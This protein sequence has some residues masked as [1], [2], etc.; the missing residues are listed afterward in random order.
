MESDIKSEMKENIIEME[1][2]IEK[3]KFSVKDA[4]KFLDRYFNIFRRMEQLEASRD[5]WKAKCM[6]KVNL[7]Y[8]DL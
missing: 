5:K 2:L 1:K 8:E 3:Q 4:N 7:S 6:G